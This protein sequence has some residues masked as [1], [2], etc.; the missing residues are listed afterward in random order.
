[1]SELPAGIDPDIFEDLYISIDGLK[2]CR[3]LQRPTE[4][5]EMVQLVRVERAMVRGEIYRY[6]GLR[7]AYRAA[8][9]ARTI[10]QRLDG[11]REKQGGM[12]RSL[13]TFL[14]GLPTAPRDSELLELAI[15][16]ITISQKGREAVARWIADPAGQAADATA[17]V[18]VIA[19]IVETYQK[20][21]REWRP[22]P[23]PPSSPLDRENRPQLSPRFQRLEKP[24]EGPLLPSAD[25]APAAVESAPVPAAAPPAPPPAPAAAPAPVPAPA[26]PAPAPNRVEAP[27]S[28][29][30]APEPAAAPASSSETVSI[31]LPR[32]VN[33]EILNDVRRVDQCRQIF[34]ETHQ[35][36]EVWEVFCLVMLDA[37]A[38]RNAVERLLHLKRKGEQQAFVD[39]ALELFEKLLKIRAQLGKFVRELRAYLATLPVGSFGRETMEMA[40]GFIVASGRG[41]ERAQLWLSEPARY[42]AEAAGRLEDIISRTMN[43]QTA[44]RM[45]YPEA[46]R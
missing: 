18:K 27:V 21:L 32:G 40:L 31:I 26:A 4:L 8:G 9:I 38:T 22:S 43:Y 24:L 23:P 16:F 15:A 12:I 3:I 33:P 1:M 20:A 11:I 42:R 44:L 25:G 37:E 39:G 5:W 14:A 36:I 17:K 28:P 2:L 34:A 30:P 19:G 6:E 29:P 7:E 35:E 13:R 46:A 41:R 45:L 10:L